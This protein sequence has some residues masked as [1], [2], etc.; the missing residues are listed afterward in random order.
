MGCT[1]K[2]FELL[3]DPYGQNLVDN[4]YGDGPQ[5]HKVSARNS[6]VAA[7]N[8]CC[9]WKTYVSKSIKNCQEI[10]F[11]DLLGSSWMGPFALEPTKMMNKHRVV[12]SAPN[13]LPQK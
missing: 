10:S 12:A 8:K 1:N 6:I 9:K 2:C 11:F 3:F 7:G 5:S 4:T 13:K